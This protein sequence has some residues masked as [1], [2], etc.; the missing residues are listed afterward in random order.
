MRAHVQISCCRQSCDRYIFRRQT[1]QCSDRSRNRNR[2]RK[3]GRPRQAR[4]VDDG[5]WLSTGGV[6]RTEGR[7]NELCFCFGSSH[8]CRW[9]DMDSLYSRSEDKMR[10]REIA[11]QLRRASKHQGQEIDQRQRDS[12]YK[13]PPPS[14]PPAG[15]KFYMPTSQPAS[16]SLYVEASSSYYGPDSWGGWGQARQ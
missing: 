15:T 10:A 16:P 5:G 1:R 13:L 11:L 14:F 6:N 2:R 4:G 12:S 3:V 7:G 8:D 9:H